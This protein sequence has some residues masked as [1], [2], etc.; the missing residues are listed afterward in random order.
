M[1]KDALS[2]DAISNDAAFIRNPVEDNPKLIRRRRTKNKAFVIALAIPVIIVLIVL[3]HMLV[4]IAVNG[5]KALNIDFFAQAQKPFGDPGGGVANAI[6]GSLI[7]VGLATVLSL[8]IS[9]LAAL[10]LAEN[11]KKRLAK[12]V[13]V[14][15]NALQGIPSIIVGIVIYTWLV[16]PMRGFSAFSG[17]V[18]LAFIMIPLLTTNMREIFA[19]VPGSYREAAL[20][21]GVPQW[22]T[23]FGVILPAAKQGILS[24]TGLGVARI[25]GE[26]APLLF[27]AFGSPYISTALGKPISAL[28]LVIYEYIKSP[29]DDWHQKAWGAA[30]IL[31]CFVFVMTVSMNLK[32]D[33]QA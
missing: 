26:T 15:V 4:T 3:G 32:K 7:V 23:A 25:A 6:L 9:I 16:I 8:P 30:F 12:L 1:S 22:R 18:A 17:S 2:R 31:V 5:S 20:S 28:P 33:K 27:T 10:Y 21:L 11:A 24:A 14:L 29:Y 19:L 13:L